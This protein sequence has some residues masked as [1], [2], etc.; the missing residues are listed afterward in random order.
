MLSPKL[1]DPESFTIPCCIANKIFEL[2]LLDMGASINLMSLSVCEF[3][4]VGTL[5]ETS[6]GI[7]LTDRSIRY[8]KDCQGHGEEFPLIFGRSFMKTAR[9]KIDVYE[10]TLTMTNNEEKVTFKP[11]TAQGMKSLKNVLTI[12][13][14]F[15]EKGGHP[16][17]VEFVNV[18]RVVPY[19]RGKHTPSFESFPL[20]TNKL[21]HSMVKVPQNKI[22]Q[23]AIFDKREKGY[24]NLLEDPIAHAT[25]RARIHASDVDVG[26]ARRRRLLQPNELKVGFQVH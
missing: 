1:K 4:N 22:F 26:V 3:L 23:P 17:K 14:E 21:F 24:S 20:S 9:M 7:Q 12:R 5:K 2:V 11:K 18:L 13:E 19:E 6:V 25:M 16:A 15:V 10:G 8:P